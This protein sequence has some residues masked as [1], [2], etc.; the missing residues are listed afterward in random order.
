MTRCYNTPLVW[1][2]RFH[3]VIGGLC[4]EMNIGQ[5]RLMLIPGASMAG[6]KILMEVLSAQIFCFSSSV[7]DR[8]FAAG[9]RSGDHGV[10]HA[11]NTAGVYSSPAYGNGHRNDPSPEI[12]GVDHVPPGHPALCSPVRLRAATRARAVDNSIQRGGVVCAQ[13]SGVFSGR[14][15]RNCLPQ[16]PRGSRC[17]HPSS[18]E[19]YGELGD[20]ARRGTRAPGVGTDR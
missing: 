19:S 11:G 13:Q 3:R 5:K 1:V 8:L 10:A 17:W 4:Q 7:L 16:Y 18:R 6:Q 14:Q 20:H 12:P 2:A 9:H 15:N